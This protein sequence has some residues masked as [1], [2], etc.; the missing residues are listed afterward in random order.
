MKTHH[1]VLEA[2]ALSSHR[3]DNLFSCDYQTFVLCVVFHL[4][5]VVPAWILLGLS[6]APFVTL[7]LMLLLCVL[8]LVTQKRL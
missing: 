6:D 4:A 2:I 8:L 7:V 5:L 1:L 3:A